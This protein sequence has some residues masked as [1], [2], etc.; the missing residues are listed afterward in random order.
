MEIGEKP[1]FQEF[2]KREN[3]SIGL[4]NINSRIKLYYG[5]KYGISIESIEGAGTKV[6]IQIPEIQEQG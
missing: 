2:S 1:R 5:E 3:G 4:K 6:T